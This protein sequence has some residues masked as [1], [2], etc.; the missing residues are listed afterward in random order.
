MSE[1]ELES[2]IDG[3]LSV[4]SLVDGGYT[5]EPYDGPEPDQGVRDHLVFISH[6]EDIQAL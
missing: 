5:I 2:Y 1:E 4:F 3:R 6:P